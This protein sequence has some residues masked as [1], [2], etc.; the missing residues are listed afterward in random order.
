MRGSIVLLNF[1]SQHCSNNDL[2]IAAY[3][4]LYFRL[5]VSIKTVDSRLRGNDGE[6]SGM[7]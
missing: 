7:T 5:P 6:K 4:G 2:K 3:K 1:D